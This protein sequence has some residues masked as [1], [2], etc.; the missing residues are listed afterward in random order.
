MSWATRVAGIL[1]GVLLS[2]LAWRVAGVVKYRPPLPPRP[3]PFP[4]DG[5]QR[6]RLSYSKLIASIGAWRHGMC[7]LHRAFPL[8][9]NVQQSEEAFVRLS[10][11][12]EKK[13][14]NERNIT[15][16]HKSFVTV[17]FVV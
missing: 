1:V 16:Y 6:R 13:T 15:V 3:A 4:L 5:A 2:H 9:E 8:S 10:E 11:K 7:L 12:E 14:R 17:A